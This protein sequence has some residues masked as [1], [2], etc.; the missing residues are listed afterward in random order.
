MEQWRRMHRNRKPPHFEI[1]G[2]G[3]G[4]DDDDD[5]KDGEH[6]G[7]KD[8]QVQIFIITQDE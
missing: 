8:R 5:R 3:D 4:D 6:G 2:N 1:A 7:D